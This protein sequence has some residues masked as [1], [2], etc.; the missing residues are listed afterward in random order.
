MKLERAAVLVIRNGVE[1][2][3]SG[4]VDELFEEQIAL[5][6][7]T[8]AFMYGR[9]VNKH[10]RHNLCYGDENQVS[11]YEEGKGTIVAWDDIPLTKELRVNIPRFLGEKARNMQG[12]GN[13]YYD[14]RKCGIG[15]H[16]DSERRLV[17]AV[18]LGADVPL[19]Y[20][21]FYKLKPIGEKIEL[22]L[23]HGDVYIMSEKATGNDWKKK[24][25]PT[26]R[27]AAGCNKYTTYKTKQMK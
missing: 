14:A 2:L 26:L 13:L 23:R 5:E 6:W 19:V 3:I 7:D 12:E 25:I 18:R 15:Y 11:K 16:G 21:W 1:A 20:Q 24:I 22:Q 9:V 17:V 27:H 10:A 8:R 4:T